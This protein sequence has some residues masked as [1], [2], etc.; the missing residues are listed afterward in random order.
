MLANTINKENS[1]NIKVATSLQ[2]QARI[3]KE[4][5]VNIKYAI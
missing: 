3:L 4:E 5:I 1:L 2:N